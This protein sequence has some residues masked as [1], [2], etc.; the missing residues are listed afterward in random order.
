MA[1]SKRPVSFLLGYGIGDFG[2]NIY[3]NSLTLI[4]VFWYTNVVGLDPQTAGFIYFV[5]LIWDAV[6]DPFV[7]S[8]A[9]RNKSRHGSYRP[10]LLWGGVGLGL[11]FCHLFW[12]PP[13]E[14]TGLV[15]YLCFAH[16]LF[17]TCYTLVAVPYSAM[18]SRL[19]FDSTERT[20]LSGVRMIFAFCGLLAVTSCWFPLS[21]YFGQGNEGSSYGILLTALTGACLATIALGICFLA[22]R[23]LAPPGGAPIA[24]RKTLKRFADA[25]RSNRVLR[26]LLVV[27]FL[28]SGAGATFYIPLAFF[29]EAN[30]HRFADKE[31]V[32]TAFAICTLSAVPVWT[33]IA[34]RIGKKQVWG[35]ATG[36]VGFCG[37]H[38]LV[39][40]PW[41]V[42]GLPLQIIFAG[43][44]FSAFAVLVWAIIPNAV[45]YGQR[46]YGERAEGAVFG[47]VLLAQ[48]VSGGLMGL[49]VGTMLSM[50]GYDGSAPTQ[51][52]AVADALGQYLALMPPA[53]LVLSW[54]TIIRLPLDKTVHAKIVDELSA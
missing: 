8:I 54:L 26:I 46:A 19:T 36:W 52:R 49:A 50:I 29:I 6:S 37:L 23:E 27:I 7:A 9:E 10:F 14:G 1:N 4:L 22:T 17:R 34:N 2:L 40:G 3:W 48:K 5:G 45:E 21:R 41:I 25:I 44:G 16:I 33:W 11:A 31:V 51:T 13:F 43:V 35:L 39:F 18:S 47:S 20:E 12:A 38:F 42:S 24:E 32:M 53:L 15:V 28:Q 30:Q